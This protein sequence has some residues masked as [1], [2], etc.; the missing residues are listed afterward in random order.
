[1]LTA[2]GWLGLALLMFGVAGAYALP[3]PPISGRAGPGYPPGPHPPP[4]SEP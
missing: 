2:A 3:S 4:D 1:V